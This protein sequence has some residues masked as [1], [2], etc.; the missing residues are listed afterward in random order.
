MNPSNQ[1]IHDG[2]SL[3]EVHSAAYMPDVEEDDV[4]MG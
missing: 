2:D 3:E 4:L 1:R